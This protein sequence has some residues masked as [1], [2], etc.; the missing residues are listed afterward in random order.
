MVGMVFAVLA[1]TALSLGAVS[2]SACR[3]GQSAPIFSEVGTTEE[4]AGR[5][6][7][8]LQTAIASGDKRRVVSMV[9]YPIAAWVGE[10]DVTFKNI[11]RL[12]ASYDRVF[13]PR[14][15]KTITDA[16][17]ECLFT[18]WQGIMIHDG[19]VWFRPFGERGLRIVKINGP[20]GKE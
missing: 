16:R 1:G 15:K 10:R 3:D 13:T 17:V 2:G 20:I 6:L 5:F 19:E 8:S 18:N 14:L 12:L 11:D 4:N 7:A 9:E